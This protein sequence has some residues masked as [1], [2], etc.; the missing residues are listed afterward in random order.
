VSRAGPLAAGVG[1]LRRHDPGYGALR[2]AARAALLM[3]ALVAIGAHVIDVPALAT[4]AAF[5]S[6][7]MLLLVSFTGPIRDRVRAQIALGVACCALIALGT[8]VSGSAWVAALVT[9]PVAFA[10][11]FA[12]VVSSTLAAATTSLLLA[13]VLPVSLPGPVSSIPDRL[14]GW[15][16]AA[17]ASVIAIAL[18]WPAPAADPVRG[19]LI[20]ACRALAARLRADV[21]FVTASPDAPPDAV[22]AEHDL[23]V[24]QGNEALDRL[25]GDFFA[26]PY[27]P[28]G[29]STAARALVR[30][31]DE[32]RWLNAVV[33]RS[34]PGRRHRGHDP[35]VCKVKRA[36]AE[37]LDAVAGLI[38]RPG[39]SPA[40]LRES[41]GRLE[42][43]VGALEQAATT[44][45]PMQGGATTPADDA[46]AAVI[47]SLDPSFRAQELSFIVAQIAAN[48]DFAAAAERRSWLA[49]VLGR[50]PEGLP[51]GLAAAQQRATSHV[52]RH[53]VWLHNSLRGAVALALAVLVSDLIGVQHAFWVVFGTLSVLRSNA[54]ATGQNVLRALAGTTLGFV[55]GALL[56][57][58]IG[59]NTTL[60]WI[61]LPF[62]VLFAG[63][64]PAAIS[65]AA[66]QAAFTLVLLILFNLLAPVGWTI[67]LVRVED[68]ALGGAVSL[69]V[70]ML[71]WP[72]GAG[73]ALGNAL[74][75]AYADTAAY[76]VR[77]V[78]YGVGRC[79]PA[80]G[81]AGP[82]RAEATRAAAA[83]RRLDDTLRGYLSERGAKL[84]SLAEITSLVTAVA[85]VRLAADAVVVLW[86]HGDQAGGQRAAARAEL[87]A[88]A[89]AM[90]TW[91]DRL[92]AGLTGAGPVPEPPPEDTEATLR[93]VES[94]AHDLRAADGTAT[95]T[96]VRVI[97][98]GDHLDAVRQLQQELV[99]PAREMAAAVPTRRS[100]LGQRPGLGRRS[101]GQRRAAPVVDEQ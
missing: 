52:E 36:A 96:G 88:G 95:A 46:S 73:V 14:A 84:S 50:R 1:W 53:S 34:A 11:L 2:R 85:G 48:A 16:L 101:S 29:L 51:S 77:A 86:E 90:R 41:V 20:A 23:A 78:E 42:A 9:A 71:F 12:G 4:F 25:H 33:L 75:E 6:F 19:A 98:T 82:P 93:L 39:S 8:L 61:L 74:S 70:G 5:G 80:A 26:T 49:R 67:G 45:L 27:R 54:L 10:V 83:S 58:A 56:V 32:L 43:A 79:D 62:A 57:I 44:Q 99:A 38:D 21:A 31:V 37:T 65:F 72:R 35:R 24:Q 22:Q 68:V 100:V 64:A 66:G 3:P 63:L 97:W 47:S 18:L 17:G 55:V 92:A 76:L 69:A 94:V 59:T 7:A 30:L 81:S 87:L 60:L 89:G 28:S 13:F 40:A 15:G 91:F